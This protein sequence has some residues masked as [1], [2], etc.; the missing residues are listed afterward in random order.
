MTENPILTL[1]LAAALPHLPQAPPPPDPDAPGP[2]AFADAGKVRRILAGAGFAD[3]ALA[4]NDM[5]IGGGDLETTLSLAQRIGPLGALLRENPDR[6]EA[7]VAAVR[8]ALAAH[9]GPDGVELDSATWI[10]TARAPG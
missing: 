4:P 2:F 9:V 8:S 7:A 6:R 5:K 3:V 10:V 1:P